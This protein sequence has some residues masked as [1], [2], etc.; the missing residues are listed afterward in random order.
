MEI[1]VVE[2]ASGT[3]KHFVGHKAPVLHVAIDPK[4]DFLVI[5]R[6]VG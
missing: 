5:I 2:I 6:L 4:L 3:V 1:H